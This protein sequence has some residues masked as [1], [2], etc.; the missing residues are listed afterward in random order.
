MK[1]NVICMSSDFST[2]FSPKQF[3]HGWLSNVKAE[4][5]PCSRKIRAMS[6]FEAMCVSRGRCKR[7]R[8]T[9]TTLDTFSPAWQPR[10]FAPVAKRLASVGFGGHV[11]WRAQYW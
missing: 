6:V 2:Q 3:L 4:F 5:D 11:S 8:D 7:L 10:Y 9:R 1:T